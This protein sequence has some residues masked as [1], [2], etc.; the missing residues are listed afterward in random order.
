MKLNTAQF[1]NQMAAQSTPFIVL[2]D[3]WVQ[4][5]P[6]GYFPHS[7]GLQRVDRKAAENLTAN[8]NSFSGKLGRRFAGAP[9]Y[10]GHPD[11]P[12][13]EQSDRDQKAYGWV[14]ALEP[15]DDGLYG[16]VKWS[17]AGSDLIANAHYKFLSPYWRVAV[18]GTQN[19]QNVVR[20]E[21]LISVGLTN[22]PNL[23]VLP[24]ANTLES[25]RAT[26]EQ[27]PMQRGQR[28]L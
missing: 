8:F 13:C 6:Y 7:N 9:F 20:P 2:Q 4:L 25:D 23:P 19:G 26:L 27:N 22:Q 16:Q 5:T 24:L 14:M 28:F 11:A 18:I 10:V 17:K 15:R 1:V 12:E 3:S 21:S